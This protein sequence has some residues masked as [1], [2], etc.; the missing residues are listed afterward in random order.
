[1]SIMGAAFERMEKDY[2]AA[3][4]HEVY[5]TLKDVLAM[6]DR[7]ISFAEIGAPIG[8]TAGTARVA[9]FRM[10]QK[11][12]ALIRKEIEYTVGTEAEAEEELLH[13]RSVLAR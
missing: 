10:R 7:M 9:A 5:T 11:L 8:M 2:G 6:P 4:K 1:M 3:G 13:L 12:K